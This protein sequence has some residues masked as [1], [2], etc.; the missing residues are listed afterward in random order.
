MSLTMSVF[1]AR[2]NGSRS[3]S[4]VLIAEHDQSER[5]VVKTRNVCTGTVYRYL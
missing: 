5:S 4:S 1:Q 3:L 2:K